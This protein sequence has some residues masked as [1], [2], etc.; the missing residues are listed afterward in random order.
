LENVPTVLKS[1]EILFWALI[2]S[3]KL[4]Q[5]QMFFEMFALQQTGASIERDTGRFLAGNIIGPRG[6]HG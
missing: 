1:E 2:L 4:R 3:Q 5:L 6:R